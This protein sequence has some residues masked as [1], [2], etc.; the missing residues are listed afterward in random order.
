MKIFLCLFLILFLN[1]QVVYAKTY[2]IL[3]KDFIELTKEYAKTDEFKKRVN[4]ERDKKISEIKNMSGEKLL[5]SD[6]DL[7]YEVDYIYTLPQDIPKAD[8][9]GNIVGILYPKGYTFKPL[10]Y[11]VSPPPPMI[12][13]NACDNKEKEKADE[14]KKVLRTYMLVS[15]G[16]PLEK[17]VQ[18]E[19]QTML[20]DKKMINLFKLKYT[21]S[22]VSVDTEKGVFNVKVY[23]SD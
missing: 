20:V 5:K 9:Q 16:C 21:V 6:K 13:F 8:R 23:K 14:L 11:L 22:V 7:E 17:V 2:E 15:S 4:K 3:E 1:Y 19:E 12:I 18:L 10:K